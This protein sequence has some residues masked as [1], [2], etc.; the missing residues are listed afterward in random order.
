MP[1]DYDLG[2][3]PGAKNI[4][5]DRIAGE[6]DASLEIRNPIDRPIVV[7]CANEFCAFALQVAAKL[8]ANGHPNVAVFVDGYDAWWNAGG[9]IEQK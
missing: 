2:H 8:K 3:L 5:W 4:P 1:E 6:A 7:Y 9:A